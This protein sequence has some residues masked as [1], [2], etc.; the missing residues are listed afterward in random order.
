MPAGGEAWRFEGL[1]EKAR[2]FHQ[3][4]KA[5]VVK[6]ICA[7]LF[8][9][10]QRIRGMENF[11]CDMMVSPD[12]A[13]RAMDRVLEI[14]LR[15]WETA[16]KELGDTI[17]VVV[18]SDDYGTQDSQL[19]RPEQFR[20]MIKPRVAHLVKHIKGLAPNVKFFFHS[21]GNVRP[22]IPDFIEIGIDIL[23]PVHIAAEG[24]D[25]IGLKRDFGNEISFWGG[26]VETQEVLPKGTPEQVRDDVRRNV[27]ALAPGGGWVF[28]TVHNIQ[29]D[30]PPENIMAM[31]KALRE[32][33]GSQA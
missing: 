6:S 18:E 4:G 15:F 28:N 22:L 20:E 1:A 29:A 25:P 9:M 14:K 2:G 26:G 21:C 33:G 11:L 16:I 13:G 17:D 7:G 3:Q 19:I 30:C 27:D 12:L 5:V 10:G 31:W 32:F 8:E 24:M 23:N